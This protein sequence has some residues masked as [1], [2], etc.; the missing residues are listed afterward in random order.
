MKT[1][2]DYTLIINRST[3][4]VF[5]WLTEFSK[6]SQWAKG[7]VSMEQVSADPLDVG[8]IVREVWW[9]ARPT[10]SQIWEITHFVP[11]QLLGMKTS[12]RDVSANG[13]FKLAA[14][15]TAT[16]LIVEFEIHTTGL[17]GIINVIAKLTAKQQLNTLRA[18]IEAG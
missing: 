12:D 5:T 14:V 8:S 15:D 4:D 17:L 10:Q 13:T 16:Q 11:N 7:L 6:W 3:A 18:L 2:L 9:G 1:K